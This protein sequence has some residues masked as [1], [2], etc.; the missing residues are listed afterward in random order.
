MLSVG[1]LLALLS[2]IC[3]GLFTAPMKVEKRWQWENIWLV[4][5]IVACLLMPF[6]LALSTLPAWTQIFETAPR[7]AIEAALTFGFAWGFGAICFGRSVDSLG[8][9]L[10]NSLVIGLSS[11]LGSLVPLM[12]SGNLHLDR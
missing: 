12:F 6:C 7:G 4:F 11:A 2:G 10:A 8:V 9:S 5:I 1:V 3:N